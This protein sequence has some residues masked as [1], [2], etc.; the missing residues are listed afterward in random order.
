M[1]RTCIG[2]YSNNTKVSSDNPYI[3]D[4]SSISNILLE[5][6]TVVSGNAILL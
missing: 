1:G 6:R 4:M 5:A 3:V 2:W